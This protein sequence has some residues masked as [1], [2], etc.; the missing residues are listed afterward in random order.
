M[1]KFINTRKGVSEIEELIRESGETLILVSPY[2]KLSKDF[3]ELLAFRNGRNKVTKI[4]FG[5]QELRPEELRFLQ[6]LRS[7]F[8]M[9]H[10]NLHAKCYLNDQ[11]MIIT[12]MNLYEYSMAVNKEMGVIIDK[13]D[14]ADLQ[15]FQDAMKEVQYI[16][17]TSV[18]FAFV[19]DQAVRPTPP[20]AT[21]EAAVTGPNRAASRKTSEPSQRTGFCIRTGVEIPFNLKKPLTA[22]AFKKWSQF[23]NPDYPEKYCH[24]SGEPSNG[25]TS[26]NRPVLKKNWKKAQ[27]SHGV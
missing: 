5:K 9:F 19:T 2:L 22:E 8:L 17:E 7:V 12:S 4:V 1:A 10:E 16:Q 11:K 26:V 14:P 6:G 25:E 18:P 24:F 23:G 3:K 20:T 21:T 27:E 15:L 13:N